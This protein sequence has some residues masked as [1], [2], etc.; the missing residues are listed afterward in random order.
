MFGQAFIE[1]RLDSMI[2]GELVQI[3]P[4]DGAAGGRANAIADL[5]MRW[6]KGAGDQQLD[7]RPVGQVSSFLPEDSLTQAP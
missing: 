5:R 6:R 2:E 3:F 4:I 1:H 7:L